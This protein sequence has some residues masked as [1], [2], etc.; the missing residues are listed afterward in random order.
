MPADAP[1]LTDRSLDALVAAV[2]APHVITDPQR[3]ASHTTDWTGRFHGWTPAVV[4]PG[5]TDE[6]AAVLAHCHHEH[7][8][9]VPQGGN[10]GLVG[11]GVPGRGE[12]VLDLRRL[13][14]VGPVDLL[15]RQVTVGAGVTVAGLAAAVEPHGLTYG[16]DFAARDTA[17]IG[18]TIATNAGGEH[19]LRWGTTRA[20][21]AGVEAVLADGRVLSHLAGLAKDNTGYD[22]AG[23]LCGSEGTLAVVTAARLRLVPHESD[24][25]VALV[26]FGSVA[27]AVAA[28]S[29]LVVS[30]PGLTAAELMLAEGVALVCRAFDRRPPL[31]AASGAAAL[32]LIENR[33]DVTGAASEAMGRALAVDRQVAASVVAPDRAGAEALWAYR[34]DHTLAIN[35]LGPPHKLDVTLPLSELAAF[36]AEVP[37]Q[38]RTVAPDAQVWQFGHLGDGNIH[39][40]VT[41]LDPDDERV[42]E[43]VLRLAAGRGGSISAEHGIGTAKRR[44]L[45]L[46]RS[47]A[48]IEVFAAIK[49]ALDP[50]GLLNPAVLI[51][52]AHP[53]APPRATGPDRSGPP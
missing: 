45:E 40:N 10:T 35:T 27:D 24:R 6:V 2:G 11:G 29:R 50:A 53:P 23:L 18:G 25:C 43:I 15:A 42:D 21:V 17:T 19:V 13:D 37:A 4:R 52:P 51:P 49:Q 31:A 44:W 36:V 14:H 12:I 3:T 26:G 20:Q 47:A 48:E 39:V 22:L 34:R 5:S 30:V 41:G 32:V 38:V 33:S 9:V 8:C 46:N 16:V 7:L 1:R 28:V